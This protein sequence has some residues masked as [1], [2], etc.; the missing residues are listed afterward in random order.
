MRRLGGLADRLARSVRVKLLALVLAPLLLGVPLLLGMVWSWGN[1]AYDRLM[2]F[3]IS[4][5]LV[6]AHEYFERVKSGVGR[7]LSA[8][9]NSR[10]LASAL[11]D[12]A[13][14]RLAQRLQSMALTDG[15]D[16]L[17]LLDRDGR[18]LAAA[19]GQ[20]RLPAEWPGMPA[21]AAAMTGAALT[22]VEVVDA[23]TLEA[24]DPALRRRAYLPLVPTEAAAPDRRSF[25]DR[26]MI[27]HAAAP[28]YDD[29]RHL[30]GVLEGGVLLNGNLAIVD[31]INAIVYKEGS[32]P[33]GSLG[34]ATLFLGD[35][36][37]ATN[38][39]LFEGQRALGTRVSRAVRDQVLG[40]GRDWLGTAFVVNEIYVSG[41]EPVT[42]GRDERV[43]MLYVG[44]LEAPLR[45]AKQ[46]GMFALFATFLV[47]SL[48]GS[49]LS[50][51]WARSVFKPI[52]R[53]NAV[54]QRVEQGDSAARVG[55]LASRDEI[56]RLAGE[57]DHLLDTLAT[58]QEELRR[59][60]DELDR[61]VMARTAEL[62]ETN[63]SLRQAQQQLVMSEKLAAI[64]ELTA[65]VAHEINNPV[66]VIQGNLDVLRE[67]LGPSAAPVREEIR[68]IHQQADRIRQIVTKLLQ[69]ARPGEFAGY[70]ETVDVNAVV[71]DCLVLTRHNL[72]KRGIRVE[73]RL[74][75]HAGVE[76]NRSELQQVLINLIVNAVQAMPAGGRLTLLSEVWLEQG[77]QL[78]TV[79]HVRDTGQGIAGEDLDRIFD[80]FF[81]TKR[82]SGTGLGLS[83]S[84]TIVQRYGGRITVSSTPGAGSEFSVWLRSQPEYDDSPSAPGF[85]ARW[86]RGRG[87]GDGGGQPL[88]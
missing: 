62:A 22:S 40:A 81:T 55:E 39:R 44:F 68:L 9:A 33:L 52:E 14:E 6:T 20:P 61:K 73:T 16:F 27:I 32:L 77:L 38:V 19:A 80:P 56:G 2:G 43:G 71:D 75:A 13:P 57:F 72:D 48:L 34:T 66:A 49:V 63:A 29:A 70:V 7:D 37:I 11:A 36:R 30:I 53:M 35:T 5:D 82:G 21:V 88:R 25:E 65:G 51:R 84:Y 58:K 10:A 83:I 24:I 4:S 31:R 64:G 23:S 59:W 78:G 17:H 46:L 85:E 1:E 74:D 28:V 86:R 54:I 69:F 8:L 12:T 87:G 41:Y 79:I 15:L 26:G 60:A 76:I 18:L 3:K 45:H 67:V 50:L 47:L 42:N